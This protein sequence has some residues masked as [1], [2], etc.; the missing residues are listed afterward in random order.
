MI[1]EIGARRRP[2]RRHVDA[3]PF[4]SLGFSLFFLSPRWTICLAIAAPRSTKRRPIRI[5]CIT[6]VF[7]EIADGR[8]RAEW[9]N[10][11]RYQRDNKGLNSFFSFCMNSVFICTVQ[12]GV[13]LRFVAKQTFLTAPSSSP[14]S[15]K[16]D[17]AMKRISPREDTREGRVCE[18]AVISCCHLPLPD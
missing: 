8:P 4:T 12:S 15:P 13:L 1:R 11:V 9:L 5:N 16:N 17:E 7:F 2:L 6:V 10:S 14:A 18:R 3:R